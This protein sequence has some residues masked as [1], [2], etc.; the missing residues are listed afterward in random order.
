MCSPAVSPSISATNVP[1]VIDKLPVSAPVNV[2]VPTVNLSTLSSQPIKALLDEPLSITSPASLEG[3]PLV[4]LPNS[5][6]ASDTTVF[7]VA[8]VVVVPLTVKLPDN[9]RLV[10][11]VSPATFNVQLRSVLPFMSMDVYVKSIS[12]GD[13]IPSTPDPALPMY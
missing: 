6:N 1:F 2:P 9:V 5:I 4:P 10:P 13:A 3:D 11:V 8:T 7:V 12:V